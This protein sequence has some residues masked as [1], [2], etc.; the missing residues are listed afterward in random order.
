VLLEPGQKVAIVV[1]AYEEATRIALDGEVCWAQ[2]RDDGRGAAG[3]R[4]NEST[5]PLAMRDLG[6]ADETDGA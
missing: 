5:V 6:F 3:V 4:F 1:R 2:Q